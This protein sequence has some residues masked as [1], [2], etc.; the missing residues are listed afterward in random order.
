M[1]ASQTQWILANSFCITYTRLSQA[2]IVHSS[3]SYIRV[4]ETW[5]SVMRISRILA[6][7]NWKY[8]VGEVF[9]IVVAIT[10]ALMANSWYENSQERRYEVLVLQQIRDALES[11]LEL[12]DNYF[13]TLQQSEHD[14]RACVAGCL[15]LGL[16]D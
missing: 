2:H 3:V 12:F 1:M 5:E 7:A 15:P 4:A 10:L 11:D 6:A 9:L 14:A 13:G 8:A 16:C